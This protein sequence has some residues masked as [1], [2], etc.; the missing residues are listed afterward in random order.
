MWSRLV[1]AATNKF[2]EESFFKKISLF[3]LW[4]VGL[5]KRNREERKIRKLMNE[6][7]YKEI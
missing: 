1:F 4:C 6:F 7:E 3:L 5:R 2:L